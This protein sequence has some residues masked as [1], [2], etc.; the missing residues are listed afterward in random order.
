M[1]RK[2]HLKHEREIKN[3]DSKVKFGTSLNVAPKQEKNNFYS[4]EAHIF[5]EAIK[6]ILEEFQGRKL[7]LFSW[8]LIPD[9]TEKKNGMAAGKKKTFLTL[10]PGLIK[11]TQNP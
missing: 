8:Y 3:S 7:P 4:Q 5:E 1:N 9:H 11:F 10:L 2:K 6:A